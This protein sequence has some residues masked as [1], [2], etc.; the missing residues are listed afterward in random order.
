MELGAIAVAALTASFIYSFLS[1]LSVTLKWKRKVWEDFPP[2]YSKRVSVILPFYNEKF[3]DVERTIDSL[4]RQDYPKELLEVLVVL[5]EG[6]EGTE[7]IVKELLPRIPFKKKIVK[8]HGRRGKWKALNKGFS[9]ANGELVVVYDA[10][11]V[12]GSEHISKLVGASSKY[13]IVTSRVLRKGKGLWGNL[14]FAETILWTEVAIPLIKKLTGVVPPSGEGVALTFKPTLPPC[15]AEDA[16]L[17]LLGKEIG[18]LDYEVIEGAPS[19][20]RSY[21]LQRARWYKGYL[22]CMARALKEKRVKEALIFSIPLVMVM[23]SI[24]VPLTLLLPLIDPSPKYFIFPISI[25]AMISLPSLYLRGRVDRKALL[26]LPLSVVLQ[27]FIV[28]YSIGVREWF[29]T[30]RSYG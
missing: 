11:D 2:S 14:S 10:G 28:L 4:A 27:G 3:E 9:E 26:F 17:V 30:E 18:A 7:E 8:V 1:S 12:F 29:K 25:V 13:P 6:D 15:L 21:A 19:T 5:E 24:A 22:Q 23:Y 20:F 16:F